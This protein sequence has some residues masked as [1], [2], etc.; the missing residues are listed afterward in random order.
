M[1]P[2]VVSTFPDPA[3]ARRAV[4]RL[5]SAGFQRGDITVHDGEVT[6]ATNAAAI[7]TD[8][9]LTGGFVGNFANLL[10]GLLQSKPGASLTYADAV[11]SEGAMVVVNMDSQEHGDRVVEILQAEGAIRV[12]RLPQAGLES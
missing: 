1:K 5:E 3:A 11:H 7:E 8:E 9:V 4:D 6:A 10:H 2:F 12:A